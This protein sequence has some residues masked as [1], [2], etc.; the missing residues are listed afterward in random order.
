[1]LRYSLEL[2]RT[3]LNDKAFDS[4]AAPVAIAVEGNYRDTHIQIHSHRLL[5]L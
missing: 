5:Q 4:S 1:M 3:L 2:S